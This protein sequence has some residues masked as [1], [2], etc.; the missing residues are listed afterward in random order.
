MLKRDFICYNY[1]LSFIFDKRIVWEVWNRYFPR[2]V[3]ILS[4]N[5]WRTLYYVV[6]DSKHTKYLPYSLLFMSCDWKLFRTLVAALNQ[7][8]TIFWN[9]SLGQHHTSEDSLLLTNVPQSFS[10]WYVFF[11]TFIRYPCKLIFIKYLFFLK[12]CHFT[13]YSNIEPT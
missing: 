8:R 3:Y 5:N 9:L 1:N 11:L 4:L 13:H 12:G 7:I 6:I 10:Q 2:F